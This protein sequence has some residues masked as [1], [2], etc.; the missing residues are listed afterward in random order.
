MGL[1]CA[2]ESPDLVEEINSDGTRYTHTPG[3]RSVKVNAAMQVT[4]S[5]LNDM[6][7]GYAVGTRE[8]LMWA[9]VLVQHM[10][11]NL[12][13]LAMHIV[14]E[15]IEPVIRKKV[16]DKLVGIRFSQFTLGTSPPE[17]TF[18]DVYDLPHGSVALHVTVD[19]KSNMAM[20][21]C[22]DKMSSFGVRNFAIFGEIVFL[23]RPFIAEHPGTGGVTVYFINPPEIA[24]EFTGLA[25]TAQ[26]SGVKNI[27]R[28]AIDGALADRVV[29]P[30]CVTQLVRFADMK[31][32]PMVMG[33]PRP[34]GTLRVT[35]LGAKHLPSGDW[36]ILGGGHE[37]NYF[38]IGL[39][40]HKWIVKPSSIGEMCEFMVFDPEVRLHV[41]LWDED[42]LTEDDHLGHLEGK[43]LFEAVRLS[44]KPLQ[45]FSPGSTTRKAGT[46]V[47]KIQYFE[48]IN[49]H[50]GS[51]GCMVMVMVR[52]I[53]LPHTM[54]DRRISIRAKLD[55]NEHTSPRCRPLT[56]LA[57]IKLVGSLM[58]DM[59]KRLQLQGFNE[60]SIQKLTEVQGLKCMP[61][62]VEMA[63]NHCMM[64]AMESEGHL[65][66][67]EIIL[68]LLEWVERK[69]PE[70]NRVAEGQGVMLPTLDQSILATNKVKLLDLKR[71]RNHV[72]PGPIKMVAKNGSRTTFT[73]EISVALFGL[74]PTDPPVIYVDR[75]SERRR[76]AW[77]T[78]DGQNRN[79]CSVLCPAVLP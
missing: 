27:I 45:L 60:E 13:Q 29:L 11:T 67:G 65:N 3:G 16:G 30:N 78:W 57:H 10:W 48:G 44:E 20:E 6:G 1:I 73:A 2:R 23:L 50:P 7:L 77:N 71:A 41:D 33:T 40:D 62:T 18:V 17:L 53:H 47:L 61:T 54:A 8:H 24:V 39:G 42:Q 19:Y 21:V 59:R 75:S 14:Q 46:V 69:Q 68:T 55:D 5:S 79:T 58:E 36:G 52:E 12:D 37:D 43:Y 49:M 4:P 25:R 15:Q 31:L 56:D 76:S 32:Y 35:L 22:S 51:D 66:D 9:N 64:F 26:L 63:C 38:R 70:K 28:D 74:H 34:I 72:L